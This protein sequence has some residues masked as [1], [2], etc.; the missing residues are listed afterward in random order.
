MRIP[1]EEA[2]ALVQRAGS[3]D[4]RAWDAL[5]EAYIGLVWSIT[6]AHRL[7]VGDAADVSQTTWLRLVENLD[8]LDDPSRVGAWLATTARR[9]CLR[10][11]RLSDRQVLV[12]DEAELERGGERQAE[13]VDALLLKAEEAEAVRAAFVRLPER[14]Q[15]ILALLMADP[16][17]SYSDVSVALRLPIGSIGPT[18]GRCLEKL[19]LLMAE[20]GDGS[21]RSQSS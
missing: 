10:I 7:S 1:P 6:R 9:E 18:R 16:P 15:E 4:E 14:C 5:V 3:G 8:R 11:L 12:E 21:K 20:A 17:P 19:R 13:P 2:A